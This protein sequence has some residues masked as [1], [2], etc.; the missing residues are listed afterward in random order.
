MSKDGW[1]RFKFGNKWEYDVKNLG[2]KYNLTDFAAS[3]GLWQLQHLEEWSNRRKYIFELYQKY[4]KNIEGIITPNDVKSNERHGFHLYVI[5][6]K[7]EN[8]SISRDQIIIKLSEEGIGTSVH[9]KPV[10]MHSFFQKKFGYK[11][12]QFP[13]SS[14]FYNNVISLPFYPLLSDQDIIY[15]LEAFNKVWIK[16]KK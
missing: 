15:I 2:Y 9:Y 12:E 6:I 1:N 4:L 3:F 10:H 13:N 7:P 8:W 11:I 5:R 16:H 14:Y